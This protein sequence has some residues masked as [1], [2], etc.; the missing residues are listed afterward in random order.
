MIFM[1][2]SL[3]HYYRGIEGAETVTSL[4][5]HEIDGDVV[6]M[7]VCRDG[8]MRA[9]SCTKPQ[10]ILAHDILENT[11]EAGSKPNPGGE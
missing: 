2:F 11:A 1:T 8:K 4:V 10:C 3:F 7:G 6:A 9:W 5:A